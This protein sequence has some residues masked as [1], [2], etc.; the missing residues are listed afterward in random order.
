MLRGTDAVYARPAPDGVGH[1]PEWCLDC[2]ATNHHVPDTSSLVMEPR[3]GP[4]VSVM[5]LGGTQTLATNGVAM[6]RGENGLGGDAWLKLDPAYVTPS[7]DVGIVSSGQLQQRGYSTHLQGAGFFI[8]SKQCT[9]IEDKDKLL[10]GTLSPVTLRYVF[11]S[12]GRGG[13]VGEL[14]TR[15][16]GSAL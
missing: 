3:T 12:Q 16:D 15:Q 8:S 7:V 4:E 10:V 5:G 11:A 13:N 1:Q 6:L 2:A 9:C 14:S